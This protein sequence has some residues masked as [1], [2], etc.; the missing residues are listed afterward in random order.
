LTSFIV[1]INILF[2]SL[3]KQATCFFDLITDNNALEALFLNKN[4]KDLSLIVEF[5]LK[6]LCFYLLDFTPNHL[7]KLNRFALSA[8]KSIFIE[9]AD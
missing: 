5:N 1:L 8:N 7:E 9:G 6:S 3:S 2:C 4:C